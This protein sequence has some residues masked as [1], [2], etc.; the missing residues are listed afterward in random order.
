MEAWE[1]IAPELPPGWSVREIDDGSWVVYMATG[2]DIRC[3]FDSE[4]EATESSW[5]WF[6]STRKRHAEQIAVER[7]REAAEAE[8]GYDSFWVDYTYFSDGRHCL[9]VSSEYA[10]NGEAF[11]GQGPTLCD[12]AWACIQAL[13]GGE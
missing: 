12:A 2:P 11:R 4:P 1:H 13:G 6:G 5:A 9:L 3:E 7:V 10:K 8:Y